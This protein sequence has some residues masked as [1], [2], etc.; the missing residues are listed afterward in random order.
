[1]S[2]SYWNG[3][4]DIDSCIVDQ[5]I[6]INRS[7][8]QYR[9]GTWFVIINSCCLSRSFIQSPFKKILGNFYRYLGDL[10][11]NT[12]LFQKVTETSICKDC[13]STMALGSFKSIKFYE[14]DHSL[15][16]PSKHTYLFAEQ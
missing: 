10:S 15:F 13:C 9:I 8:D 1:M 16:Y 7:I 12:W 14:S 2:S 3:K 4:K 5:N 6:W 11:N